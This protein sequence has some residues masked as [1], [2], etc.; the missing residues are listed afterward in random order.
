MAD[1]NGFFFFFFLKK[2]RSPFAR[3]EPPSIKSEITTWCIGGFM[4]VE[5]MASLQPLANYTIW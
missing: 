4:I 1:V 5:E 2:K 3:F